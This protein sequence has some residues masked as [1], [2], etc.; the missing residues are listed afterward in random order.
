MDEATY[1]ELHAVKTELEALLERLKLLR[2][3]RTNVRSA[4]LRLDSA[5]EHIDAELSGQT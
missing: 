3:N 2:T 5:I 1:H 4:C